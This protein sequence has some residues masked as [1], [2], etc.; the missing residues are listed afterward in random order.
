[1]RNPIAPRDMPP[2]PKLSLGAQMRPVRR[3][4]IR[5][6]TFGYILT[7]GNAVVPV[8]PAAWQILQ[9]LNGKMTLLQIKQTFGAEA[10]S[11]IGS[12]YQH[13]LIEMRN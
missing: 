13:G 1:M 2:P 3:Y 12:L 4:Q 6:E 7:R 8:R 10:L 9:A 5:E 11:L